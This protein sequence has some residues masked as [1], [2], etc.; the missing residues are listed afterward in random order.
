MEAARNVTRIRRRVPVQSDGVLLRQ[1]AAELGVVRVVE[2][3]RRVG[4][5]GS[6]GGRVEEEDV[7]RW[8]RW[9]MMWWLWS[10]GV[11]VGSSAG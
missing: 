2:R 11:R 6:S 10:V 1:G 3:R 4:E 8:C 5:C 7:M 9:R